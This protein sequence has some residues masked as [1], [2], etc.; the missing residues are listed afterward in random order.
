MNGCC[1]GVAVL[2]WQAVTFR[3][4]GFFSCGVGSGGVLR[5]ALRNGLGCDTAWRSI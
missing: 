4:T 2:R 1:P 3:D 5:G